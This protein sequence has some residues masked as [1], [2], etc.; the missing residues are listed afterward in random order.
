[1]TVAQLALLTQDA[2][3]TGG[4]RKDQLVV[5]RLFD[6]ETYPA[7]RDVVLSIHPKYSEKILEEQKT[8]ELRRRFPV[9]GPSAITLYIYSTSPVQA[10]VGVAR[11]KEVQ[12]LPVQ[13]I[14]TE[15][16][17]NASVKYKDFRKY[18]RGL[19][20]GFVL[21]LH[22]IRPFPDPIPLRRLR[23]E[24]GFEPPQSFLYV[25]NELHEALQN[26]LSIQSK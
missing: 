23:E 22:D 7:P 21:I 19:E 24:F 26:E 4:D 10:I 11:I 1:M 3:T 16:K 20:S 2:L 18:F 12:E 8:V 25:K 17:K 9:P 15:F 14:W 13:Q 6:D 5:P